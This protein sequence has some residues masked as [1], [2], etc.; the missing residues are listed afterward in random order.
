M[1]PTPPRVLS[2]PLL[3]MLKL[4]KIRRKSSWRNRNNVL[5][6]ACLLAWTRMKRIDL[7]HDGMGGTY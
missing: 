2:A 3:V 4:R 7:Y 6:T 5:W 1:W